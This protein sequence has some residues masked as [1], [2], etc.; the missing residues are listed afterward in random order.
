[1]NDKSKIKI[2]WTRE[3]V[4]HEKIIEKEPFL[5]LMESLKKG[6]PDENETSKKFV[7]IIPELIEMRINFDINETRSIP[8]VQYSTISEK[9]GVISIIR[10]HKIMWAIL[11]GYC[12]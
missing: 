10:H 6:F 7:T 2:S 8:M 9:I 4:F 1:M 3:G 11:E 5:T 12:Q